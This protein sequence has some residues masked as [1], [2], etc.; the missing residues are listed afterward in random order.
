VAGWSLAALGT[1]TTTC[2]HAQR[3][4]DVKVGWE[5]IRMLDVLISAPE[6]CADKTRIDKVLHWTAVVRLF[7][8]RDLSM[9]ETGSS[10][11]QSQHTHVG[12]L[13]GFV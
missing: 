6:S 10:G 7:R 11:F 2:V 1:R 5:R 13:A 3:V 4:H 8:G 12:C 9:E